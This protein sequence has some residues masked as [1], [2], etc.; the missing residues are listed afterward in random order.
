LNDLRKSE[1]VWFDFFNEKDNE[2]IEIFTM[3]NEPN[4]YKEAVCGPDSQNWKG[5]INEEIDS[6]FKNKTWNLVEINKLN[7]KRSEI[8][9]SKW[10]F[11]IKNESYGKRYKFSG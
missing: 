6:L 9:T 8:I 4:T 3:E 11:K 10:V 5:A 1:T 2:I 7:I